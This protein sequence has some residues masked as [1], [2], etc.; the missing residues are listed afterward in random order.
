MV[1]AAAS[2]RRRIYEPASGGACW[3][4]TPERKAV[5]KSGSAVCLEGRRP[6]RCPPSLAFPETRCV[7]TLCTM[8]M[9]IPGVT[10]ILTCIYRLVE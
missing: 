6:L 3:S 10:R 4:N 7:A 2:Q 5:P 9:K 8:R 1:I